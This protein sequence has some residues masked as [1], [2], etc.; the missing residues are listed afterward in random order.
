MTIQISQ[1][2]CQPDPTFYSSV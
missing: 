1:V 2:T